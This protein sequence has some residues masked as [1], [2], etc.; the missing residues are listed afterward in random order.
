MCYIAGMTP[1]AMTPGSLPGQ[2][3]GRTP[4]RDRLNINPE[5]DPFNQVGR[6][7]IVSKYIGN[8]FQNYFF[9]VGQFDHSMKRK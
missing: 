1:G 9:T 4:V 7:E 5:D 6:V 8:L 2:T 3:P